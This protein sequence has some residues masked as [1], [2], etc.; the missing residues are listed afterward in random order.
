M[1][2]Y[3]VHATLETPRDVF[4][5]LNVASALESAEE[6]IEDM[7]TDEVSY[8]VYRSV[9]ADSEDEAREKAEDGK[10][11]KDVQHELVDIHDVRDLDA[12]L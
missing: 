7:G 5:D 10:L 1:T 9:Y 8:R 3:R 12:T 11:F 4:E 2:E 6:G